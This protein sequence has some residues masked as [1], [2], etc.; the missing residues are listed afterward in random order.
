MDRLVQQRGLPKGALEDVVIKIVQFLREGSGP[1]PESTTYLV[2]VEFAQCVARVR[3]MESL[4]QPGW[5]VGM[6]RKEL[7]DLVGFYK[8]REV[9]LK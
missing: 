1:V 5:L 2:L 3:W 4:S 8:K 7:D 6:G 9:K